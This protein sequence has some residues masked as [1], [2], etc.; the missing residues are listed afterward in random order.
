MGVAGWKFI[1]S[2]LRTEDILAN[3]NFLVFHRWLRYA[4]RFLEV[5]GV[6]RT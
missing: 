2:L 6:K 4:N 3:S 5:R 1:L